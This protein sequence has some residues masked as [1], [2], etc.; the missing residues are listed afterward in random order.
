MFLNLEIR[1]GNRCYAQLWVHH[2]HVHTT[3][4][5]AY[6]EQ[7]NILPDFAQ[8]IIFYVRC[9]DHIFMVWQDKPYDINAYNRYTDYL[10]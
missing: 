1:G 10:N 7:T 9:I 4:F 6:L 8:I 5:F 3:I 2:A